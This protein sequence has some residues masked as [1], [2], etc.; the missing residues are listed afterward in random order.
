MNEKNKNKGRCLLSDLDAM[1]LEDQTKDSETSLSTSQQS[2]YNEE[3]TAADAVFIDEEFFEFDEIDTQQ[4]EFEQDRLLS[5][6]YGPPRPCDNC[7]HTSC[8]V[9]GY[10]MIDDDGYVINCPLG[11]RIY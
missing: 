8:S 9:K 3:L 11:K 2:I 1:N 4:T 7:E 10:K 6:V 5:C